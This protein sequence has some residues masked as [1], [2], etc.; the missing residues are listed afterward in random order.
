VVLPIELVKP[1]WSDLL[2]GMNP[3]TRVR[4]GSSSRV[5]RGAIES[6]LDL[7]IVAFRLDIEYKCTIATADGTNG[8]RTQTALDIRIGFGYKC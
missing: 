7:G 4:A 3:A 2:V 6:Y 8:R 1:L 5:T